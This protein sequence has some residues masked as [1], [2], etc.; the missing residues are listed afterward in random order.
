MSVNHQLAGPLDPISER[1]KL[2][3]ASLGKELTGQIMGILMLEPY[4]SASEIAGR[5]GIHIATAQKYLMEMK[6]AGIVRSR[7]RIS[8]T[9]PTEEYWLFS[10]RL[11]IEVD[12]RP[13]KDLSQSMGN[14]MVIES[15][16]EM[17]STGKRNVDLTNIKNKGRDKFERK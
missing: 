13:G 1:N 8:P 7:R 2:M 17:E 12:L 4:L 5:I 3:A 14:S 9:R 15:R 16:N 11:T 10:E 6:Q